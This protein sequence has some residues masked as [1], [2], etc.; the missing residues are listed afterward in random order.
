MLAWA[1]AAIAGTM[2]TTIVATIA[3]GPFS[4]FHFQNLQPYGIIGNAVTLPLVSFVVMP[5]AVL[6]VVTFPFGLD[7]PVWTVMGWAVEAVL[8]LAEWVSGIAG[9]IVVVPAFGAGA[10]ALFAAAILAA[11]IFVSGLRWAALVPATL[12]LCLA[13]TSPRQDIYI[14]RDGSAAAIR[15]RSG[16]LV[17]V[18]RAPP[19][20]T[21]QWLKAD[22][23]ARRPDDPGLRDGAA[24]D[25][26][27]CVVHSA[28]GRAVSFLA[29]RRGFDTDCRRADIILSR[30]TAPAGCGAKLVLDRAF[31]AGHGA[32]AVRDDPVKPL[33]QTARTPDDTRPWLARAGPIRAPARTSGKGGGPEAT[34]RPSLAPTPAPIPPSDRPEPSPDEPAD[35]PTEP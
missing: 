5:A 30:L 11:T 24:C 28:G 31:L 18:G 32:T 21:E 16:R 19:F 23:D 3:T 26:I 13:A 1:G 12:G 17:I 29:D 35:D 25:P 27:G 10:L 4:S 33:V 14:A 9:S 8:A 22:G 6:G 2:A 15:G 7:R 34:G 20:I